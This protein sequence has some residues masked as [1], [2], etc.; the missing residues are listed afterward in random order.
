MKI[1][2]ENPKTKKKQLDLSMKIQKKNRN[3]S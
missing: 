2:K 1:I 3:N